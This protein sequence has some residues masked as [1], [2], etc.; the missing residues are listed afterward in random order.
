[1]LVVVLLLFSFRWGVLARRNGNWRP[2]SSSSSR[3]SPI[4]CYQ[5]CDTTAINGTLEVEWLPRWIPRVPDE[6]DEED[7]L[8]H[9][10]RQITPIP[11]SLLFKSVPFHCHLPRLSLGPIK[12]YSG[13]CYVDATPCLCTQRR[14]LGPSAH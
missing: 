4:S 11:S 13:F 12:T 7:F 5:W 8:L 1:M 3:W 14:L 6:R 10:V 9:T 2:L